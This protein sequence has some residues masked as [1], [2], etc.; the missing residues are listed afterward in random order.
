MRWGQDLNGCWMSSGTYMGWSKNELGR[1]LWT[2]MG[3]GI[4]QGLE[5]KQDKDTEGN[6]NRDGDTEGDGA[7]AHCGSGRVLVSVC[8]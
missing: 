2:G 7:E 8:R 5:W 4:G 6:G 3:W 1:G